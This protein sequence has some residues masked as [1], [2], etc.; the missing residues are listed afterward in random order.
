MPAPHLASKNYLIDSLKVS[1]LAVKRKEE[2]GTKN[3]KNCFICGVNIQI[4]SKVSPFKNGNRALGHVWMLHSSLWV[5]E[6][7][8]FDILFT[9]YVTGRRNV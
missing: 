5:V 6:F 7:K 1:S 3:E 9:N 4:N 2:G 8:I